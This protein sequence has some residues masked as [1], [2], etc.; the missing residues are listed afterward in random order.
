MEA[1]I[2]KILKQRSFEVI[3]NPLFFYEICKFCKE[4]RM[5]IDKLYSCCNCAGSMKW[6]HLTCLKEWKIHKY[7]NKNI[8][9]ICLTKYKIPD[10]LFNNM[11]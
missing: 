8:C 7:R 11:L 3:E 1:L 5:N 6:C 2:K 4:P 9:E 10:R